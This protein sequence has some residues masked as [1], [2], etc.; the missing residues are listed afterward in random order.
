MSCTKQLNQY[1]GKFDSIKAWSGFPAKDH[2]HKDKYAG[3]GSGFQSIVETAVHKKG[4]EVGF[5]EKGRM[6]TPFNL[7]R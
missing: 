2:Q 5:D 1:D 7:A 6:T 4:G 3:F